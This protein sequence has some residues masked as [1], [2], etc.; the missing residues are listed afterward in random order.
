M[1]VTPFNYAWVLKYPYTYRT[2]TTPEHSETCTCLNK[3]L[4]TTFDKDSK[5]LLKKV[6]V[7]ALGKRTSTILSSNIMNQMKWYLLEF[8]FYVFIYNVH[9]VWKA[10]CQ[11]RLAYIQSGHLRDK[12]HIQFKYIVIVFLNLTPCSPKC[13]TYMRNYVF[14]Y[15]RFEIQQ[16]NMAL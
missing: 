11:D 12:V 16:G 1:Q 15:P 8:I 13:K 4:S 5:W 6:K 10:S 3:Q 2:Q 14:L 7:A 9:A